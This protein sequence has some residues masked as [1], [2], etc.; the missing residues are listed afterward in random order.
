M[1]EAIKESGGVKHTVS[2]SAIWVAKVIQKNSTKCSMIVKCVNQDTCDSRKPKSLQLPSAEKI[3]A[4][5]AGHEKEGLFVVKIDFM[6]CFWSIK[7]CAK[8]R[9]RFKV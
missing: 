2:K 3:G 8:W 6:N 4:Q 7:L 1:M 5:L 9:R